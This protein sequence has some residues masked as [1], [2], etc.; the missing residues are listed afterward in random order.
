[1]ATNEISIGEYIFPV[2]S[3]KLSL[4][5]RIK[6]FTVSVFGARNFY[7]KFCAKNGIDLPLR[8]DVKW[9]LPEDYMVEHNRIEQLAASRDRIISAFHEKYIQTQASLDVAVGAMRQKV[10]HQE[11]YLEMEREKL[12]QYK[13][14]KQKTKDASE[15]IFLESKINSQ[16]SL[17]KNQEFTLNEISAELAQL[18]SIEELN[19]ENW[20][21]QLKNIEDEITS[22]TYKFILR[23]GRIV[24]R[25][26]SYSDFKYIKPEYSEKV[27]VI[28][29]MSKP[30]ISHKAKIKKVK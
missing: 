29:Q 1:M 26:L 3:I 18:E 8:K 9:S 16:K 20:N 4:P 12:A 19:F 11:N 23:L 24:T 7:K 14:Q 27:L 21:D 10:A 5:I 15:L 6:N 2:E 30:S 22:Q 28:M 17:I 25:K 13:S